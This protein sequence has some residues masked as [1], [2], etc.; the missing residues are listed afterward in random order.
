M[1]KEKR[2]SVMMNTEVTK[3][4]GIDKIESI[5]FKKPGQKDNENEK[6][7]EFYIKPD[8]I[9]AENGLGMPKFDL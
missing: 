3:I 8:I 4:S 5:Y 9:I 1:L 2:I 7:V 6:N